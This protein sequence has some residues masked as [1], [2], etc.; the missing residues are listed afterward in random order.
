M[1]LPGSHHRHRHQFRGVDQACGQPFL[2]LKIYANAPSVICESAGA[3]V[4]EVTRGMGLD[5]RIGTCFLQA[6]LRLRRPCFPKDLSAFIQISSQPGYDFRLLK[7]VQCINADQMD[8]FLQEA[9]RH[10]V[11]GSDKRIGVLDRPF[12]QN[13]DDVRTSPAIE[14][15]Q[16]ARKEA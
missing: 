2:A 9:H 12:K 6:G 3:N 14:V 7:E 13:T 11:G 5:A 15:C 1:S 10:V 4:Q 16:R 8:R